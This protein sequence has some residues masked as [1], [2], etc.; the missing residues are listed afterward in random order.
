MET[1]GTVT[2]K[3]EKTADSPSQWPSEHVD[4]GVSLVGEKLLNWSGNRR[5]TQEIVNLMYV[6]QDSC[7]FWK[8]LLIELNFS[9]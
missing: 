1:K 4:I 7:S 8:K 9:Y 5:N 2:S 3:A 6:S